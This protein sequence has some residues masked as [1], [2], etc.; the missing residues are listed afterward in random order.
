MLQKSTL[1]TFSIGIAFVFFISLAQAVNFPTCV[2]YVTDAAGVMTPEYVDKINALSK[3]ID[4]RTTDEVAVVTVKSL[5]GLT[6]EDYGYQLFQKC[7]I[8]KKGVDNGILILTGMD[9]RKWRI[10]VGYGLEG[11]VNDAKAGD[12][13]RAYITEY[14]KQQRYGEGLYLAVSA[15]DGLLEPN[16]TNAGMTQTTLP[17]VGQLPPGFSSISTIV[18]LEAG[19]IIIMFV[20]ALFNP[21][22][23]EESF[24]SSGS[25]YDYDQWAYPRKCPY[26]GYAIAW[27]ELKRELDKHHHAAHAMSGQSTAVKCPKCGKVIP[28]KKRTK[29]HK[30]D[31]FI[32]VPFGGYRSGGGGG[33]YGG[34]GGGGFG[35][36]GSG[37]GG[38]S[39]GW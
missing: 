5:E 1:L 17:T 7:G 14:F 32:F 3:G 20:V 39:G 38:A 37:G 21:T 36:G 6:V 28:R 31:D 15:I 8:G 16:V 34:G 29:D 30:H 11:T 10:E 25:D 9:D 12:I 33:G 35:G 24:T 26:C 18:L 2:K 27:I 19:L 23:H 22:S 13:G 4:D